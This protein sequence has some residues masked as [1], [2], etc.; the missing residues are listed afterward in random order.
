[1]S[2]E[3]VAWYFMLILPSLYKE[4]LIYFLEEGSLEVFLC[5]FADSLGSV[6]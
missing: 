1:M 4:I 6:F 5:C 3:R 2:P